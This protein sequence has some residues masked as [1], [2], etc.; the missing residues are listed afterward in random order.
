MEDKIYDN[1]GRIVIDKGKKKIKNLQLQAF[2]H[3]V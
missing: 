2:M 1:N 3:H